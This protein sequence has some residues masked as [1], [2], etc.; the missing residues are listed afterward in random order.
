MLHPHHGHGHLRTGGSAAAH[1]GA[2]WPGLLYGATAP[3]AGATLAD[4]VLPGLLRIVVGSLGP[5]STVGRALRL[6][7]VLLTHMPDPAA[8][9]QEATELPAAAD[10]P[11]SQCPTLRAQ[12]AIVLTH[13]GGAVTAT[14]CISEALRP[15]DV[16]ELLILGAGTLGTAESRT[17]W[18]RRWSPR[19]HALFAPKSQWLNASTACAGRPFA[20][21]TGQ[22]HPWLTIPAP[23]GPNRCGWVAHPTPEAL[24]LS[25]E[26]GW[27]VTTLQA[28]ASDMVASARALLACVPGQLRH[29]VDGSLVVPSSRWAAT[30]DPAKFA[31]P[32][33]DPAAAPPVVWA[34]AVR[35]ALSNALL[36]GAA[37]EAAAWT[38]KIATA[39]AAPVR[40][41]LG[42]VFVLGGFAEPLRQG[43]TVHLA[44]EGADGPLR[45]SFTAA[46][47]TPTPESAVVVLYDPL[48]V[49]SVVFLEHHPPYAW[50][51]D[52]ADPRELAPVRRVYN[53]RLTPVPGVALSL[54]APSTTSQD[55]AA[56]SAIV[57]GT[58]DA[59]QR[60]KA[61]GH[62][63]PNS[64]SAVAWAW[65][66][67]VTACAE[68]L[69]SKAMPKGQ[70]HESDGV[71]TTSLLLTAA[72]GALETLVCGRADRTTLVRTEAAWTALLRVR[73]WLAPQRVVY[74]AVDKVV[75]TTL[76]WVCRVCV[77]GR[78][79][80]R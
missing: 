6:V 22:G 77:L 64:E 79:G 60:R 16:V 36:T 20:P 50:A 51:A 53:S 44:V 24:D 9:L 1:T 62:K 52:P 11:D 68:A 32:S 19:T 80:R 23:G 14:E 70:P 57:H 8:C 28:L 17:L 27:T 74:A 5:P 30:I 10:V 76:A 39:E 21:P 3:G 45:R 42:A 56:L 59:R 43:A 25:I 7:T 37:A 48:D 18:A 49:A 61:R 2:W 13:L 55:M 66:P 54:D 38:A 75:T 63:K 71:V 4:G 78:D 72:V 73:P 33:A 65:A 29:I 35:R 12:L 31:R 58:C 26:D 41:A 47:P 67:H 15:E 46:G 69:P 34:D 40:R